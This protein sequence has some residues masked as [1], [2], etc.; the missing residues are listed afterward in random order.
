M[1]KLKL[2]RP[3]PSQQLSY[4]TCPAYTPSEEETSD[5][6]RGTLLHLACQKEQ[7]NLAENNNDRH[8]VSLCLSH[9]DAMI[10]EMISSY[11]EIWGRNQRTIQRK[12]EI[13]LYSAGGESGGTIDFLALPPRRVTKPPL[14]ALII[15]YKF[16]YKP[17]APAE[18]NPQMIA[19]V[20]RVLDEYP[21]ITHVEAAL[22]MPALRCATRHQFSREE[23]YAK[24]AAIGNVLDTILGNSHTARPRIPGTACT[25][26]ALSATCPALQRDFLTPVVRENRLS[27]PKIWDITEETNEAQLS[28]YRTLSSMMSEFAD[29]VKKA[30][31]EEA[32]RRDL[33]ALP[34]YRW[35]RRKGDT[36]TNSPV[37]VIKA[38]LKKKEF[39]EEE[40]ELIATLFPKD[41]ASDSKVLHALDLLTRLWNLPPFDPNLV[42]ANTETKAGSTYLSKVPKRG[43]LS[44]LEDAAEYA[45]AQG[46]EPLEIADDTPN[47]EVEGEI[48]IPAPDASDAPDAPDHSNSVK[49][50]PKHHGTE[51]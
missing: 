32:L 23:A 45:L 31:D 34:G 7:P 12:K 43:F 48:F 14:M 30:V 6:E 33:P 40:E 24:H 5:A 35:V 20:V 22:L 10:R 51:A 13:T 37:M 11:P 39:T 4:L 19:Y 36:V 46:F 38:A 44:M 25:Y 17:V 28:A 1:S 2:Y 47:I 9:R 42:T 18:D 27:F 49:E 50:R 8:L 15:D 3:S 41:S 29:K 21:T 26:C 16:G